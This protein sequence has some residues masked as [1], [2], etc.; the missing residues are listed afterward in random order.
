MSKGPTYT[1]TTDLKAWRR[2]KMLT[3]DEAARKARISLRSWNGA[4]RG[5]AV[6]LPVIRGI[7]RVMG[8]KPGEITAA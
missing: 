4:E 6:G 3:Q 1:I 2:A 7:A 8:V 5:Q